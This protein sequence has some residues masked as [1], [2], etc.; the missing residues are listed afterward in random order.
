[1]D[2]KKNKLNI[3][4]IYDDIELYGGKK[5]N[6]NQK[7][8]VVKFTSKNIIKYKSRYIKFSQNQLQILDA[9]LNDGGEKKYLDSNDNLRYSE[10]SG[11]FDFDKTKLERIIISGKTSRE[12]ADDVDILLPHNMIDAVDYEYMFHTHPPTPYPGAR[13]L[14][15]VL[16][17]FPSISDLF[18]FAYHYNEGHVQGS[19]VIAPEGIYIIKMKTKVKYIDMPSNKIANKME[20]INFKI[21]DLAI[22]VYGSDFSNHRQQIYYE[23]VCNDLKYIKYFNKM[24][25]QYFHPQMI[26]LYKPRE[27]DRKTNKWIIK[28]LYVKVEPVEIEFN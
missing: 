9:L 13:A 22:K 4:K 24:V 17:E 11:L 26:V 21:Q 28:T 5:N 7:R 23:K 3:C 1:M 14:H 18:H 2:L 10:H 27:F 6:F 15:G 16:Y 8:Y 19:M 25:Q 20:E 12:D